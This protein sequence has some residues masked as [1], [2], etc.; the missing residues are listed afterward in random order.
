MSVYTSVSEKEFSEV[1]KNYTLGDFVSAQGIQAGVENTNYFLITTRGKYVFTLFEKI[2][3]QQLTLYI[4][5]LQELSIAGIVCPQPQADINNKT[6]NQLK[7]KPFTIVTRLNGKNLNSANA[8]HCKAV[9]TELAKLHTT[10]LTNTNFS[11]DLF[12][13]RRGKTWRENTAKTLINNLSSNDAELLSSE[14]E[15]QQSFDDSELPRG[16]I[17]ADLFKDNALFEKDKLSGVIDLYDACYDSYLY[18]ISITI[19]AWCTDNNGELIESLVTAF[20]QGYQSLRV[21]T[22][23]EK[24]AWP[25]MLRIAAMRFWLSR[26]EDSLIPRQGDLTHYKDPAEYQRILINHIHTPFFNKK[27]VLSCG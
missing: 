9:A 19:N 10:P 24:E 6:I 23:A 1:L 13:N 16:I 3:H 18:D 22:D 4:S 8:A 25:M 11:D 17:H 21:L 7:N 14:L 15:L 2:N 20:L 12:R 26:L 5:L 27:E